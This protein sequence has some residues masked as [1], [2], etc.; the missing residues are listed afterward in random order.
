MFTPPIF[1]RNIVSNMSAS[2]LYLRKEPRHGKFRVQPLSYGRAIR[3]QQL[4]CETRMQSWL[5]RVSF[6]VNFFVFKKRSA[7]FHDCFAIKKLLESL[8]ERDIWILLLLLLFYVLQMQKI[9][10]WQFYTICE[11]MTKFDMNCPFEKRV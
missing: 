11:S 4:V 9:D 1:N 5:L 7:F 10:F 8:G 6:L 3:K 2:S